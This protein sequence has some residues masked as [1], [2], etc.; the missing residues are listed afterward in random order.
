MRLREQGYTGE[1][2]IIKD[3]VQSKHPPRRPQATMRYETRPGEQ[4]QVHWGYYETVDANGHSHKLPALV[5]VL[6]Y[7]RA[8]YVEFA[9]RCDISSF[10]R[11][12]VHAIEHFG[13][14]S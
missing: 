11:C 7:S 1:A 10:L 8:I 9:R 2:T 14:V 5:M 3:Y 6:G 12:F 13:G 4:A